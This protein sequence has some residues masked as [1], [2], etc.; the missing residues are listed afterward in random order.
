MKLGTKASGT[1]TWNINTVSPEGVKGVNPSLAVDNSGNII[2]AWQ[3]KKD[4]YQQI[5]VSYSPTGGDMAKV[6]STFISKAGGNAYY[7]EVKMDTNGNALVVWRWSDGKNYRIQA[8][9]RANELDSKWSTPVNI[10]FEGLDADH[11]TRE[12]NGSLIAFDSAGNAQVVWTVVDKGLYRIQTAAFNAVD[13]SWSTPVTV[14]QH[15]DSEGNTL[16]HSNAQ[17]PSIAL[18]ADG[19]GTIAWQQA[20]STGFSQVLVS[21]KAAGSGTQS[22]NGAPLS[23]SKPELLSQNDEHAFHPTAFGSGDDKNNPV[24]VWVQ[25]S[26]DRLYKGSSESALRE[27]AIAEWSYGVPDVADVAYELP[28]RVE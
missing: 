25:K 20:A 19:T 6:V 14:S 22:P 13:I 3:V 28:C 8:A 7:P 17:L 9:Y 2:S 18:D 12:R 10:S 15:V 5:L 1:E 23:W 21:R 24:V 16:P 11:A 4:G 27:I 26:T